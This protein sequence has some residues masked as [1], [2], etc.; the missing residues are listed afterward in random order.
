MRFTLRPSGRYAT[1]S[2]TS[3]GALTC[4]ALLFA[5]VS[6]G[7]SPY[8]NPLGC[9][10]STYNSCYME[11]IREHRGR[12]K[13]RSIWRKKYADCYAKHCNVRDIRDGFVDGFVDTC[14]GGDGCPPLFAPNNG[15]A[16]GCRDACAAAWFQGY[17]LGVAA[18]EAC[19]CDWVP[20]LANPA[21]LACLGEYD[22][23]NPGCVPCQAQQACSTCGNAG[24]DCG[25]GSGAAHEAIPA[26]VLNQNM[27][28]LQPGETI[29]PG[30]FQPIESD[31][32]QAA[33]MPAAPID[34]AGE[35]IPPAP[36][37]EAADSPSDAKA[38]A[39]TIPEVSALGLPAM[40]IAQ[41]VEM[42]KVDEQIGTGVVTEAVLPIAKE[43]QVADTSS[44]LID[45]ALPIT[46]QDIELE[47]SEDV[48]AV[49]Y[50]D[51]NE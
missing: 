16:I 25:C 46:W 38:A 7:C 2:R 48:K 51:S 13:A 39:A 27:P 41:T 44:D 23:C 32:H 20:K 15:C 28:A 37:A 34:G 8:R 5:V 12:M 11:A 31:E 6:S 33:P 29:V 40:H 21:M 9:S 30:S 50:D 43:E 49:N 3:A 10:I 4:V 26:G 36:K 14:D 45:M 22:A 19:G 47:G 42:P 17:P 18:A 1:I 35:S 24:S